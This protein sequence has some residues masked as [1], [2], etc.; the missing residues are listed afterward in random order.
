MIR[1]P[2]Y[3]CMVCLCLASC[4]STSNNEIYALEDKWMKALTE[5]DTSTMSQ[6]LLPDFILNGSAAVNETRSQYL[7]TAAMPHRSLQ[8]IVL[9]NRELFLYRKTAI[10]TGSTEYIGQW[11]ANKFLLPVRY[12][13]VWIKKNRQWKVA[14]AHLS[15]QK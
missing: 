14:S 15:I 3:A 1:K 13:N 7:E 10:S 8:P 9:Q 6:L 4:A 11:K 12:T 2:L 5:K